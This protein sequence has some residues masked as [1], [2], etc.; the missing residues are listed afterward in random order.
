MYG[1]DKEEYTGIFCPKALAD[2]MAS[3]WKTTF[4]KIFQ[5]ILNGKKLR[6]GYTDKKVE[7]QQ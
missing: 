4:G 7:K 2:Y 3:E 1:P 5:D 6:F